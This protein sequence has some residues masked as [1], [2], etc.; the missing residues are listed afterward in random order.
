MSDETTRPG[1][2]ATGLRH[3]LEV[4]VCALLVGIVAVTFAQVVWR[5]LLQSPLTWSEEA[6]RFLFMWL[7]ALCS[8]YGF[9][10]GSHFA[11]RLVHARLGPTPRRVLLSLV[12]GFVCAFLALFTWQAIEYCGKARHQIA[13]ATRLPMS[14]PYASAAVGGALML[15]Y[16]AIAGWR[17]IRRPADRATGD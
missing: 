3:P 1:W 2:L 12:T 8:A 16:A 6:A 7:A 9:K 10:E 14:V 15:Y 17:E 5:Y 13:P 4:A 11:L